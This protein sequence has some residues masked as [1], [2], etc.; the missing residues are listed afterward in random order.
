ML[1][2][3]GACRAAYFRIPQADLKILPD[4]K[5]EKFFRS[6]IFY[7][8]AAIRKYFL[9]IDYAGAVHMYTG[10]CDIRRMPNSP[11]RTVALPR[12]YSPIYEIILK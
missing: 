2:S 1:R 4:W 3:A 6:R 10:S 9:C 11:C 7:K 8:S 12:P 5:V